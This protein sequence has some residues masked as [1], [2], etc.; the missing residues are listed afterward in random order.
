[1]PEDVVTVAAAVVDHCDCLPQY[2]YLSVL[3][4]LVVDSLEQE[5]VE[6]RNYSDPSSRSAEADPA[7]ICCPGSPL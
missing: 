1:M 2:S 6:A 5:L 4:P 7:G 3:M